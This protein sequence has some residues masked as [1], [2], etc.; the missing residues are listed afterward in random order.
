MTEKSQRR[1]GLGLTA[2]AVV[3]TAACGGTTPPPQP[4]QMRGTPPDLRGRT[5]LILPAQV[6]S[7]VAGDVDAELAFHL[8]ERGRDVSWVRPDSVA[9][10]LRRS[11]GVD[12]STTGLPVAQFLYAEVRRVGD[13]LF[14]QLRR[15]SVLVD[16]DAVL[17]PVAASFEP[18]EEEVGSPPRVRLTMTL[19]EPRTGQ[20]LWFGVEEGG[21]YA[22]TD[23]RA[24][25]TAV[26][27]VAR[28]L[29]WYSGPLTGRMEVTRVETGRKEMEEAR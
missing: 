3:A 13:P 9:A 21:D 19:I 4:G 15:M 20:V 2:F 25:A 28:T 27:Q 8:G 26:E 10:I 29:L 17:I 12:A 14:G 5:V 11:P 22:R 16:A 6:V 18:N 1:M 23:P 7:G 24:L